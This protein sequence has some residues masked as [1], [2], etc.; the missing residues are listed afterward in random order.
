MARVRL[1]VA[2]ALCAVLA[3]APCAAEPANILAPSDAASAPI[4]W[5]FLASVPDTKPEP[6]ADNATLE[7]S[8]KNAPL[9]APAAR[10]HPQRRPVAAAAIAAPAP[11]IRGFA[12]MTE[13]E[14]RLDAL[15]P[16]TRLGEAIRDAET[17][18]WRRARPGLL[19]AE[20]NGLWLSLDDRAGLFARGY[21][22]QPDAQNPNGNTG[23]T[24]GVRARF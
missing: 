14:R 4:V 1:S 24:V 8:P 22:V 15:M 19:G 20:H 9:L 5:E 18:A 21:H 13:L 12:S 17:P 7:L 16:G 10:P 2:I 11:Q 6:R 23:A 3:A